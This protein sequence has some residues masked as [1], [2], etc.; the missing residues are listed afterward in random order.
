MQIRIELKVYCW[1]KKVGCKNIECDLTDMDRANMESDNLRIC[2]HM[3]M[4]I[5]MLKMNWKETHRANYRSYLGPSGS[6]GIKT[7]DNR[8][9][10]SNVVVV[11]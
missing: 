3:Y 7:R 8:K 11:V 2:C 10:L 5:N 9:M 4:Q 1:R 6:E